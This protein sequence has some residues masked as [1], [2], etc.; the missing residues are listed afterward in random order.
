LPGI[1]LFI[2][3]EKSLFSSAYETIQTREQYGI[4][5]NEIMAGNRNSLQADDGGYHS[6]IELYNT[7]DN[8]VNLQAWFNHRPANPYMWQFLKYGWNRRRIWSFGLPEKIPRSA[9]AVSMQI[10]SSNEMTMLS[11]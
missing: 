9:P 7:A 8:E 5:I 3:I 6:Y 1:A 10:S 11:S 2:G 4:V